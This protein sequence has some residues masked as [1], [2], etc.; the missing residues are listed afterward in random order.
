MNKSSDALMDKLGIKYKIIYLDEIEDQNPIII[1]HHRRLSG[2]GKQFLPRI[3][4]G[5][6]KLR[7]GDTI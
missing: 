7:I 5:L 4:S 3:T 2:M 1:C 6:L